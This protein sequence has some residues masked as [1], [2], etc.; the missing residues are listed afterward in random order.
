VPRVL[1][2]GRWLRLIDDEGW[3]YAERTGS[4]GVAV[5]VA[6]TDA[7]EL[8]LVEQ[9]RHA[10]KAR[11]IE[12]P[13]G[14]VGDLAGHADEDASAAARRELREETGYEARDME[15]V[16]ECPSSP[17][18]VSETYRLYR[19]SGLVR[20]GPGGGDEGEDITVHVIPLAEVA[21]FLARQRER[22]IAIDTK[23]FAALWLAGAPPP[24]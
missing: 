8:L 15:F 13:A 22:G 1:A 14:L 9:Y 17:G 18:M 5:I 16:M 20:R 11:V 7:A 10:V 23:T 4:R 3:E 12:P 24:A 2:E 19:A 21:D 6:V